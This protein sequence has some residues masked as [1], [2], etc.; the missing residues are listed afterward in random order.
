MKKKVKNIICY[1]AIGIILILIMFLLGIF[2]I[3]K[4]YFE[5]FASFVASAFFGAK[6]LSDNK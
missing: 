3:I 5:I 6:A 4:D 1:I 2:E